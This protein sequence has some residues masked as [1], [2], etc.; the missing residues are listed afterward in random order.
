MRACKRATAR[1]S[2]EPF[3]NKERPDDSRRE[4]GVFREAT[5]V[6][7]MIGAGLLDLPL[8]QPCLHADLVRRNSG[9]SAAPDPH[10]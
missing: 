1:P 5:E 2:R 7:L 9:P 4:E 8:T 6:R 10:A 3:A